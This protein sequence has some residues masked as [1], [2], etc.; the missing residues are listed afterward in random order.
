MF[1]YRAK[2][3]GLINCVLSQEKYLIPRSANPFKLIG[4]NNIVVHCAM[5]GI[6]GE[7][8]T[9]EDQVRGVY[10]HF[11]TKISN[12]VSVNKRAR[13]Y[14]NTLLPTKIENVKRTTNKK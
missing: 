11:K 1:Y 9:S 12:I 13:V 3:W 7:E 5:N 8:V 6:R 10:V 2:S 14:V 4:F